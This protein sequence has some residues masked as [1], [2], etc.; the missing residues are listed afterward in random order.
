MTRFVIERD[1]ATRHREERS[2]DAI[3]KDWVER[4]NPVPLDC[5]ASLA[6]TGVSLDDRESLGHGGRA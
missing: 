2:D 6:M 5:F 3:Q 4:S 1:A